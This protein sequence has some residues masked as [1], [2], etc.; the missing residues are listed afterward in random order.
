MSRSSEAPPSTDTFPGRT[1]ILPH[2]E[3][4]GAHPDLALT[5]LHGFITL[6]IDL[7]PV[8]KLKE[9]AEREHL[10]NSPLCETLGYIYNLSYQLDFT[11]YNQK[12]S[13]I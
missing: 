5:F 4:P 1:A 6:G 2:A 7:S 8:R 13:L 9:R 11:N 10:T 3:V 12:G